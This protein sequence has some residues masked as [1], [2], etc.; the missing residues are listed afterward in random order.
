VL[1][2]RPFSLLSGLTD[3]SPDTLFLESCKHHKLAYYGSQGVLQRL[4]WI[5]ICPIGQHF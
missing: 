5:H 1:K 4:K 2:N 3:P